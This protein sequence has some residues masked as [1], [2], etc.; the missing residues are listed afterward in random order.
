M[1]QPSTRTPSFRRTSA[2]DTSPLSR[3]TFPSRTH[4]TSRTCSARHNCPNAPEAGH[5]QHRVLLDRVVWRSSRRPAQT[6]SQISRAGA[7]L[8]ATNFHPQPNK[9]VDSPFGDLPWRA[10][11]LFGFTCRIIIACGHDQAAMRAKRLDFLCQNND[12]LMTPQVRR[13]VR[14][15]AA[16]RLCG[17]TDHSLVHFRNQYRRSNTA[18]RLFRSRIAG[19]GRESLPGRKT[20]AIN[21]CDTKTGRRHLATPRFETTDRPDGRR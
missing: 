21:D 16:I 3:G 10:P 8:Q 2:I 6:M 11:Q 12:A 20:P 18:N 17:A 13:R 14:C 7:V 19:I 5:S 4:D 9:A 1:Q 15:S